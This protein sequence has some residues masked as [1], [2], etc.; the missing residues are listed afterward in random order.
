M[1]ICDDDALALS[2]RVGGGISFVVI[3]EQT[4][5]SKI[6]HNIRGVTVRQC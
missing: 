1:K 3:T 4:E 2:E 6:N 5:C